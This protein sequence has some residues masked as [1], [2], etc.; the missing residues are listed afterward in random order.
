MHSHEES[1]QAF[2]LDE[3]IA[4]VENVASYEYVGKCLRKIAEDFSIDVKNVDNENMMETFDETEM[5]DEIANYLLI[6]ENLVLIL[7]GENLKTT[8]IL[9]DR[10]QYSKKF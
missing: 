9:R 5:F 6:H 2:D 4:D 7:I 8:P 1:I 3:L 10:L